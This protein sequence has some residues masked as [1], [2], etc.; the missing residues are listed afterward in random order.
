MFPDIID[1]FHGEYYFLS[2]FYRAE[3]TD[4]TGVTWPSVEHYYQ[5]MKTE[6]NIERNK[7]RKASG[8][9]EAKRMG[10]NIELRAK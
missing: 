5:A 10:R 3:F 7:I 9:S 4:I 1:F 8:P 2:N 6:D